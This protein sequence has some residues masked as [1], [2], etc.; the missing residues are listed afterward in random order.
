[1][2]HASYNEFLDL[3]RREDR[4]VTAPGWCR[5]LLPSFSFYRRIGRRL[6]VCGSC[7]GARRSI[8]KSLCTR[9][10]PC[11][12]GRIWELSYQ[13]LMDCEAVGAQVNIDGLRHL[14]SLPRSAVFIGNHMSSLE[15]MALLCILRPFMKSTYVIKD[16]LTRYPAV[17]HLTKEMRAIAVGRSNPAADLKKV[18][19]EGTERLDDGWSVI[20]F[21]QATRAV[22]FDP[23][24][25]N[26]LGLRLARKAKAPVVPVALKTDFW[27]NGNLIKDLGRIRPEKDIHFEF[28]EP[29]EVGN[30]K[31][32][33]QRVMA[34][35]Q[36]RLSAWQ[37]EGVSA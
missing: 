15:T 26:T 2:P 10:E 11:S 12:E 32:D 14:Q 33:H 36:D 16:E 25:F 37:E 5:S 20:V 8:C 4:Y 7:A 24:A 22:K 9:E 19:S 21:P 27:S 29:F 34:F 31:A 30:V 17:K 23:E 18:I 13:I 35:I 28:G 1:M 3:L 6:L